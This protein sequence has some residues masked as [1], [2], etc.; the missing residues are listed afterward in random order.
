MVIVEIDVI[1][2][3]NGA[4]AEFHDGENLSIHFHGQNY[5]PDC[6]QS[7]SRKERT[8]IAGETSGIADNLNSATVTTA[9]GETE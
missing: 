9:S 4:A 1:V 6:E 7:S 2:E 3:I 5:A 8:R